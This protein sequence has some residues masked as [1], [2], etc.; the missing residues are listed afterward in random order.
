MICEYSSPYLR[1]CIRRLEDLDA[2]KEDW[3]CDYVTDVADDDG[4][5]V[6]YATCQLCDCPRVRFVHHMKHKDYPQI[7]DVGC[8]CAGLLEGD[9]LEAMERERALANKAQRRARFLRRVWLKRNGCYSTKYHGLL[10][11][12]VP[13]W[14]SGYCVRACGK[15]IK[16]YRGK[17]ITRPRIAGR[18]AFELVDPIIQ[19]A[20]CEKE[21]LKKNW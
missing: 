2:P 14:K 21:Y 10:I 13:T 7:L 4:E 18:A 6:E 1:R 20:K 5:V 12:I 3:V 17:S 16:E 8:E 11:E 15:T 9:L 19:E